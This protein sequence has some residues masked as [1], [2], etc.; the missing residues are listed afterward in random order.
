MFVEVGPKKVLSGLLKKIIPSDYQ[1]ISLQFDTPE[2][3]NN[4]LR[5]IN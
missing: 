2:S 4:C 3:L 1:Y 5:E